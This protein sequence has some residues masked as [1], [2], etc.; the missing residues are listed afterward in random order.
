MAEPRF[1]LNHP[2]PFLF[3]GDAAD[4]HTGLGRIGHDL[5][6]LVSSMPEFKV[7][8]LGRQGFG[9]ARFPWAQYN[10]SER[11]QWGEE[12]I[13]QA[14]NDLAEDKKGIIFTCW[15]ASRLLWFVDGK[16]SFL[17]SNRFE[18]WAYCMADGTGPLASQLPQEQAHVLSRYQRVLMASKWAYGLAG[19]TGP[20][21][22]WLP[23]PINRTIFKPV[24]RTGL[25]LWNP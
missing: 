7:G 19:N 23:H 13:E 14:W 21:L 4:S 18:R 15:D 5:A 16:D 6:W 20:D 25:R 24:P 1:N 11:D 2:V 10:F 9:R 8:Y 12:L 22:D 3:L 17:Q